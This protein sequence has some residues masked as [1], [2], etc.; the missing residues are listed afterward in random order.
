[1]SP[2]T[3]CL[4]CARHITRGKSYCR[5]H[6][7]RN[8]STRQWRELRAQILARDRYTC[9]TCGAPAEHVDHIRPLH[10]GGSDQPGNLAAACAEC[11]LRKGSK[12]APRIARRDRLADTPP[13]AFLPPASRDRFGGE[14]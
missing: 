12:G 1:M 8:G 11:N 10:N 14:R 5:E 3:A 6:R 4:V 2:V 7:P 13:S 9:Q